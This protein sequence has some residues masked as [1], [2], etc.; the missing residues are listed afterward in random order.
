V[1][2]DEVE[3]V[4]QLHVE[5]DLIVDLNIEAGNLVNNSEVVNH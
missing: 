5:E 3:M 2:N 1:D 4:L